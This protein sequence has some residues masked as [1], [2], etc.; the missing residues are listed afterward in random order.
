[1]TELM[2]PNLQLSII[3]GSFGWDYRVTKQ[4]GRTVQV[5]GSFC[6]G[7]SATRG[8]CGSA[9]K[10]AIQKETALVDSL[11][12]EL[13]GLLAVIDNMSIGEITNLR[14]SLRNGDG[15]FGK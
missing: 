5:H 4:W 13:T 6:S 12:E 9:T 3:P 1:M 2:S 8:I 14:A 15:W 10:Q 11:K 7:C